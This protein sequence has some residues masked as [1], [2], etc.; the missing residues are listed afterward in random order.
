MLPACVFLLGA[1]W[2]VAK[3]LRSDEDLGPL[4]PLVS[5]TYHLFYSDQ[6]ARMAIGTTKGQGFERT[7]YQLK[8][9]KRETLMQTLDKILKSD[10]GWSAPSI[11][12]PNGALVLIAHKA[13]GSVFACV[14]PTDLDRNIKPVPTP[15]G[16]YVIEETHWLTPWDRIAL[17]AK[18]IT[19]DPYD[20]SRRA[21]VAPRINYSE[22]AS[23]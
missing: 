22:I 17:S 15:D 13:D 1:I 12:Y 7:V 18:S 23:R 5:K 19:D 14:Q 16:E 21:I 10:H 6:Q 8:F 2:L 20:R 9:A 4:K 3:S 11:T